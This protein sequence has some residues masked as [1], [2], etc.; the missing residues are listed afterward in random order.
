LKENYSEFH[1]RSHQAVCSC[2]SCSGR[3]NEVNAQVEHEGEFEENYHNIQSFENSHDYSH[4]SFDS[5]IKIADTIAKKANTNGSF[6]ENI[7][8]Y[9]GP[10]VN[11]SPALIFDTFTSQNLGRSSLRNYLNNHFEVIGSPGSY[12][13]ENVRQGDILVRRALGEGNLASVSIVAENT[14][15]PADQLYLTELSP[16]YYEE[17]NYVQVIEGGQFP[18]NL[19]QKF[20]R[21]LTDSFNY[22]EEDQLI[23]RL[24]PSVAAVAKAYS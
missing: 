17:G 8:E 11:L 20:A 9:L 12:L 5:I 2:N 16:E 21:R 3:E 14:I 7:I 24:K 23:L 19:H 13:T 4:G 6:L 15:V 22:L 10:E 18:K 1:E